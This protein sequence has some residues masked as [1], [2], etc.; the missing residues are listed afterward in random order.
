MRIGPKQALIFFQNFIFDFSARGGV[1]FS[2]VE[3]EPISL[4]EKSQLCPI[5]KCDIPK[6][7][8]WREEQTLMNNIASKTT[9]SYSKAEKSDFLKQKSV[10]FNKACFVTQSHL[11]CF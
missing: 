8:Y 6:C 2:R 5:L 1:V 11:P 4:Y 9:S 10:T 7:S 3:K